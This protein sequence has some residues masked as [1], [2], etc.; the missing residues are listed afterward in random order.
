[1]K[2]KNSSKNSKDLHPVAMPHLRFQPHLLLGFSEELVLRSAQSVTKAC[3]VSTR[4]NNPRS[5]TFRTCGL[6]V[7]VETQLAFFWHTFFG[8]LR[9]NL[10]F[11]SWASENPTKPNN[12]VISTSAVVVSLS[13]QKKISSKLQSLLDIS[14]SRHLGDLA[15]LKEN[16]SSP[17]GDLM[18]DVVPF[19]PQK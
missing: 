2:E 11:A 4:I 7:F 13:T 15:K 6:F 1:M 16:E 12:L 5:K 9:G 18:A 10:S 19:V 14:T 8:S 3:P 17:H